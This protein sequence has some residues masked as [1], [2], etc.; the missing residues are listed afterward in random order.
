[1]NDEAVGAVFETVALLFPLNFVTAYSFPL[2]LVILISSIPSALK[3]NITSEV[4][5]GVTD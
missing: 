3:F 2:A 5:V 4:P 1:M